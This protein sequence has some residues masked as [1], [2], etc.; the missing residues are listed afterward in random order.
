MYQLLKKIVL[1]S[2][3]LPGFFLLLHAQECK[4]VVPQKPVIAGESFSVQ[5]IIEDADR[6]SSFIPPSFPGFRLVTGPGIYNGITGSPNNSHHVKNMVY[7]LEAV[8][9]GRFIINGALLQANNKNIQSNNVYVQVISRE[10][11]ERR[12]R[13]GGDESTYLI[14]PGEDPYKKIKENLFLK[15]NVDRLICR[16]GEPV[17]A[18]FKLY[19]RLQSKSDIVKNPGFYGFTVFDMI[20]LADKVSSSEMVNGKTFDVH[21]IRKVQLYPMQPGSFVIDPMQLTN[22][23]EFSKSSV[24]TKTEQEIIEGMFG[25][26]SP[27]ETDPDKEVYETSLSTEPV[28]ITVKPLP[29]KN[30][31]KNYDAAV[32]VFSISS[33]LV[34]NEIYPNEEGVLQVVVSGKGNFTQLNVPEIKWPK[35]LEAFEPVIKDSLDKMTVP[36]AGSRLYTYRFVAGKTGAYETPPVQLS[37]FNTDTNRYITITGAT[38]KLVVTKST[39]PVK[40]LNKSGESKIISKKA[41]KLLLVMTVLLV[42]ATVAVLVLKR[43][44]K[45]DKKLLTNENVNDEKPE[46]FSAKDWFKR[47]GIAFKK[48]DFMF[49]QALHEDIWSYFAAKL[50]LSGSEMNK[51][52]LSAA[53]MAKEVA[54]SDISRIQNLLAECEAGIYTQADLS[55]DK[56]A[57]LTDAQNL[58]TIIN[59]KI[60]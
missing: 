44:S 10:E 41:L 39:E 4:T 40:Q 55:A 5:Y 56:E 32:G 59:K 60:G 54:V 8:K 21:T 37:Y 42:M 7:T 30:K 22:R 9:P 35:D 49:Y 29:D 1:L 19:S 58:V 11:A 27:G 33:H 26:D 14:R 34:K 53:L 13:T 16:V 52:H 6:V 17:V 45:K 15:V 25:N 31:S 20:N 36:L 3:I 38:E 48:G 24:S 57:M 51:Q 23:I 47:S 43:R 28:T 18:T 50:K 12:K 46:S 2:V